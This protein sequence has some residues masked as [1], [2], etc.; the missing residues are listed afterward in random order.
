MLPSGAHLCHLYFKEVIVVHYLADRLIVYTAFNAAQTSVL[1][2]EEI[3][4][5]AGN[6]WVHTAIWIND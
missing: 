4:N 5:P 2:I 6:L 3:Q 1:F